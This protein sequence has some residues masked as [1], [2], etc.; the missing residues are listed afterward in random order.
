[1][2]DD[3]GALQALALVHGAA[4]QGQAT[5]DDVHTGLFL[6]APHGVVHRSAGRPETGN[7]AG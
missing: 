6:A 2:A 5:F 1:M 7:G 4:L 3:E